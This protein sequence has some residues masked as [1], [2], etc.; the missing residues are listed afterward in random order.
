[1]IIC[2]KCS[3]PLNEFEDKNSNEEN[4][5][6]NSCFIKVIDK[7]I[8]KYARMHNLLPAK[9]VICCDGSLTYHIITK[10]MQNIPCEV[11]KIK[12]TNHQPIEKSLFYIDW[13]MDDELNLLLSKIMGGGKKLNNINKPSILKV[14]TEK[15][16]IKYAKISNIEFKPKKKDKLLHEFLN[17]F[18]TKYKETRYSFF[19]A[20][21]EIKP[22][23]E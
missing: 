11:K 18:E 23:L 14:I 2:K 5:F 20:S 9:S 6:C 4:N 19:K 1:M 15:E 22:F 16:A 8:R 3:K 21:E 13:T 12:E 7:R 10:I 17:K